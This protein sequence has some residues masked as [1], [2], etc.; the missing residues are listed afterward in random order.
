VRKERAISETYADSKSDRSAQ[1]HG[2][3]ARLER[4]SPWSS[5][6]VALDVVGRA[7]PDARSMQKV[8]CKR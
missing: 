8:G 6:V 4:T 5:G 7:E 3:E 2:L 1:I